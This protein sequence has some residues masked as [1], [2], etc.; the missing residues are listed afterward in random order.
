M[1]SRS[2]KLNKIGVDSGDVW[3]ADPCHIH[4][5]LEQHGYLNPEK[6]KWMDWVELLE[7]IEQGKIT[8]IKQVHIGDGEFKV[9][10][11]E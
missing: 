11:K 10:I 3:I 5:V 2:S 9:A 4:A 8:D 7:L 1:G 6:K